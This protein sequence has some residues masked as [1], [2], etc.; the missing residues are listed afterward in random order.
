[1]ACSR[2]PKW[3][4]RPPGV[5]GRSESAPSISVLLEG[6]RSAE[7]PRRLGIRSAIPWSTFPEELRVAWAFPE[8]RKLS[9]DS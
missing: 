7:P 1:M 8:V 3:R 2:T 9:M 6:A 4:F 5:P